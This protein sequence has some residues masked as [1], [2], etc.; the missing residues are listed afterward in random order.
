MKKTFPTNMIKK[1]AFH[2][3]EKKQL[4]KNYYARNIDANLRKAYANVNASDNPRIA[5]IT[6]ITPCVKCNKRGRHYQLPLLN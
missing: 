6:A 3:E 5:S 2:F 1:N 4:L